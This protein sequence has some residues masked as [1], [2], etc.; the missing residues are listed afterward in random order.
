MG[1]LTEHILTEAI[2][3]LQIE[4]M[5][6][7]QEINAYSSV[8]PTTLDKKQ[9]DKRTMLIKQMAALNEL[10]RN[11]LKYQK[12]QNDLIITTEQLSATN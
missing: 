3:D 4:Q 8:T 5:T 11:L 2:K 6:L 1:G 10:I 7:T 9:K 12:I